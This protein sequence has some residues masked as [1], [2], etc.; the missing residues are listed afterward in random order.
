MLAGMYDASLDQFK[1]HQ[2]SKPSIWPGFYSPVRWEN[3]GFEKVG[4]TELNKFNYDPLESPEKPMTSY[5]VPMPPEPGLHSVMGISAS[6]GRS[7][8]RWPMMRMQPQWQT[9]AWK[10]WW[11]QINGQEDFRCKSQQRI[12]KP[13]CR[14]IKC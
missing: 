7:L 1:P 6:E 3:N 14:H 8:K 13:A 11:F 4:S 9:A 10:K 12:Q 2:W 5:W